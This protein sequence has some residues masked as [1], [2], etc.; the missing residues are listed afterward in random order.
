MCVLHT[1]PCIHSSFVL[2]FDPIKGVQ[3][4][5]V[6]DLVYVSGHEGMVGW[7]KDLG[8]LRNFVVLIG[9][10]SGLVHLT[11]YGKLIH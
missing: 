4:I 5:Q 8:V 10:S 11:G 3:H 7:T 9:P 1:P 2:Y 6:V